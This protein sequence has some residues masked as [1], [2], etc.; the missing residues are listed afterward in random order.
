MN[1]NLSAPASVLAALQQE[2]QN[3]M[4]IVRTI[5]DLE[6]QVDCDRICGS[7]L[8]AENNLSAVIRRIANGTWRVLIFDHALCYKRLVQDGMITLRRHRLYLGPDDGNRV[9]FTPSDESLRIGCYGRFVPEDSI[10][11][12]E[13]EGV[14]ESE[15]LNESNDGLVG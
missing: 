12:R 2:I 7:W 9:L 5:A 3:R 10:R 8:S 4:N 15:P 13:D 11:S 1:K 14:V 6:E